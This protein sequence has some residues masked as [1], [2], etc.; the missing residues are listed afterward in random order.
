MGWW[1]FLVGRFEIQ[2]VQRAQHVWV[3][4]DGIWKLLRPVLCGSVGLTSVGDKKVKRKHG[5]L[6]DWKRFWNGHKNKL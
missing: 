5:K 3:P 4:L 2:N 1:A 6:I